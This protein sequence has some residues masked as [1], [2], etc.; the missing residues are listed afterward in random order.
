MAKK[1]KRKEKRPIA[2]YSNSHE[3]RVLKSLAHMRHRDLQ[4]ACVERG[5]DFDEV[6]NSDHHKLVAW[7]YKNFENT[8]D[9]NLLLAY[10]IHVDTLLAA[11]G[12]DPR[13]PELRFGYVGNLDEVK[14]V[15]EIKGDKPHVP[16]ASNK[17]KAEVDEV[18]KVRK[19]TKKDMTYTMTRDKKEVKEIIKAVMQA[20]PEAQEK[21][22]K[23]WHK[24]A[25][26]QMQE[27]AKTKKK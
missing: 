1:K 3:D 23:I 7:Y 22:I 17:P 26:K 2:V 13:H 8:C 12:H 25:L 21:S 14:N 11:A 9:P 19:G 16:K 20:F 18:T 6:I 4:K 10:D 5:M 27:E 24:R 15:R